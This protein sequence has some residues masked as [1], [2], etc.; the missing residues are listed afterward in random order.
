MNNFFMLK[1]SKL[2]L[3]LL[4]SSINCYANDCFNCCLSI[5]FS[6]K[7]LTII[8]RYIDTGCYCPCLQTRPITWASL[9]G[10]QSGYTIII[11]L[12]HT[13]VNPVPPALPESSKTVFYF[14][15]DVIMF[16]RS[17]PSDRPSSFKH[18]ICN[19]FKIF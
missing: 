17:F 2:F 7:E 4:S 18:D 9:L 6:S 1:K 19:N 8:R 5:I 13:R 11:V 12:A 16:W 14:I 3:L 15:K 10:F